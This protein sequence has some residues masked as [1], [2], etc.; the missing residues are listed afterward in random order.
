MNFLDRFFEKSPN[1]RFHENPS[2]AA[3]LFHAHRGTDGRT[4]I[5]KLTVAF[6]NKANTPNNQQTYGRTTVQYDEKF[7]ET[8]TVMVKGKGNA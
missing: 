2:S 1:I 4:D 8:G 7:H 6:P 5:T 3:Q